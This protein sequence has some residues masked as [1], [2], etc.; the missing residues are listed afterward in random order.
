MEQEEQ[1]QEDSRLVTC[2]MPP[3]SMRQAEELQAAGFGN[4]SSILRRGLERMWREE[5]AG[6][7][8]LGQ[9]VEDVEVGVVVEQLLGVRQ[10]CLNRAREWLKYMAMPGIVDEQKWLWRGRVMEAKEI[11]REVEGLVEGLVE[12]EEVEEGVDE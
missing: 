10:V 4:R 1:E 6:Y 12:V 2:L 7:R 9:D 8:R 3:V 5:I 11:I